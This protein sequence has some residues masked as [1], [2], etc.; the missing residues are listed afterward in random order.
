MANTNAAFALDLDLLEKEIEA[1]EQDRRGKVY[2][3][4][5]GQIAG[6]P[7]T[8]VTKPRR[9]SAAEPSHDT[10]FD[11]LDEP[12]WDTITR[13]L[14]LVFSLAF[15]G[16]CI[17]TLNIKLLGGKIS[18]FQT[19]CVIG[20]CL[21]PSVFG[22]ITCKIFALFIHQRGTLHILKLVL[23]GFGFVWSTYASM[24]FLSGTQA[25][26]R[27]LLGLYPVILFYFIVSWLVL[28]NS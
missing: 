19:L 4:L 9:S 25:D 12:I 14:K 26:N 22:A 24:S 6:A 13:D 7:G 28:S 16:S 27:R 15:F 10:D 3:E 18:F 5:S 20:Y 1:K 11:T 2:T 21:L 17:V 23:A 8:S